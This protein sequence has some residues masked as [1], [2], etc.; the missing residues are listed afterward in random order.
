MGKV[1]MDNN[2]SYS[3]RTLEEERIMIVR[4]WLWGLSPR[5]IARATGVSVST[6]HRWVRR[7]REDGTVEMRSQSFKRHKTTL[8]PYTCAKPVQRVNIFD[9]Q[10]YCFCN[11]SPYDCNYETR[12]ATAP[13]KDNGHQQE[14]GIMAEIYI[15]KIL[16]S[17][18]H[19][20]L[21]KKWSVN[22][23]NSLLL[24]RGWK[25]KMIHECLLPPHHIAKS[26][27]P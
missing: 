15:S 27:Y 11:G 13:D 7:W 23:D 1:T 3:P 9:N 17:L 14:R 10:T 8:L 20:E 26:S 2:G 21:S 22:E 16:S 24:F 5:V 4:M 18:P 19:L 25:T 6:V 12:P